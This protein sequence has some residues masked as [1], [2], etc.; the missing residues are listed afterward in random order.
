MS[1]VTREATVFGNVWTMTPTA[2]VNHLHR[3]RRI[4]HS[5]AVIRLIDGNVTHGNF[6]GSDINGR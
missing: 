4:Q 3:D 5:S 2:M 6:R 1:V